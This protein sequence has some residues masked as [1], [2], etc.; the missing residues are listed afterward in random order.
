[1]NRGG[2]LAAFLILATVALVAIGTIWPAPS[3]LAYAGGERLLE[4]SSTPEAAVRNLGQEIRAQEWDKAYSSL[5]NKSQFTEQEFVHDVTGYYESLRTYSSLDRFDVR[6]LHA[7]DNDAEVQFTLDW[8]TVVGTLP[9]SRTLHLVR[10]GDRWEVD[11]PMGEKPIVPP[12]VIPVEYLR[13]DV[14][15]RGPG[16]DWGVQDVDT[17]SVRIVDM[18]PVQRAEGVV[19]LGELLNEDVVPAYV[20]VTATLRGKDQLPIATK[21]AFDKISH[22]LLPKQVTPFL[23]EFPDISLSQVSSIRMKPFSTL[24]SASADPVIAIDNEQINPAPGAS[25]A[26]QLINQSGQVVNVA[27]VLG[28]L[29][30]KSGNLVWVVDKYVDRALLPQTPVSFNIPIPEDLARNVSS[31][32]TVIA[33][34][35][36]GGAL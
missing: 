24:V 12:Q 35:S 26:G 7:S 9:D 15:N 23:I 6:P 5:A 18:H 30:D 4:S 25:L 19:V 16:D 21:A 2:W 20:S 10:N 11:W 34:Y 29:Y 22:L 32:R 33:T 8:S 36:F 14:I 17:P 31:Q 27:H 13:W 1:M 3:V 28:T